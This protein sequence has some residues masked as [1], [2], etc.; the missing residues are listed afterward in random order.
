MPLSLVDDADYAQEIIFGQA[1]GYPQLCVRN[2]AQGIRPNLSLAENPS[3]FLVLESTVE[4]P[5]GEFSHLAATWDG[6][7]MKLFVNGSPA[8]EMVVDRAPVATECPFF[9]GG[10]SDACGFNG[11][12]FH[13]V[14]DEL[15]FY[16]RALSAAEIAAI[17]SAGVAGKCPPLLPPCAPTPDGIL[18]WW[19]GEGEANDETGRHH[20]QAAAVAYTNGLVGSAMVFDG[21]ASQVR[22]PFDMSLVS[23]EFSVETWLK[24]LGPVIDEWDQ[25]VVFGQALGS[26]SLLVEPGTDGVRPVF[27]FTMDPFL[28]PAVISD[29]EL[30]IHEFSHVAGTWDGTMLRIYVN[31]LLAGEVMPG[32]SLYFSTCDFFIG[33][34]S[35]S[36][37]SYT[38]DGGYFHGV[39]DELSVYGRALSQT[40]IS[41]IFAA[42]AAGKCP[43]PGYVLSVQTSPG[44]SVLREPDASEYRPGQIVTLTAMA[45]PG[46]TFARWEGDATGTEI[47]ID[48]VMDTNK[49]V[50]AVFEDVAAPEI[51]IVTPAAGVTENRTFALGGTIS[52]NIAVASA[53]WEWNG[54]PAGPLELTG[55]EFLIEG[56]QLGWGENHIR[57]VASDTTGNSAAAHVIVQWVP[58]RILSVESPDPIQE[59]QSVTFRIQ[60]SSSGE[61]GGASFLLRY[62]PDYLKQPALEW[63]PAIDSA[64][65]QVN[66]EIPGE[67]RATFALPAVP[68]PPG[69]QTLAMVT[70]R[71]RSVPADLTS[72]LELQLLDIARP[73]GD[74]IPSG[75]AARSGSATILLRRVVGD[76]NANDR[77]DAGDATIVQR[78]LIGLEPVRPWDQSGN[79][80]NQNTTLD[81]GDVIRILRAVVGLDPQPMR[82]ELRPMNAQLLGSL[83]MNADRLSGSPG[84]R[85]TLRVHLKDLPS[86]ISAVSLRLDYPTNALRLLNSQSHRPGSA[87]PVTAVAVWNV[88]PAQNDYAIQSGAVSVAFGSALP[89]PATEGALA[90]FVF[91]VQEG[92]SE[93]RQWPIRLSQAEFTADGYDMIAFPDATLYFIGRE[94][95]QPQLLASPAGDAESGFTFSFLG[96]TGLNYTVEVSND[97]VEWTPLISREGTD[98][99]ITIQ[100]ET[101]A[102]SHQRYYRVRSE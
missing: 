11:H 54:Q 46:F 79:D 36:C 14:I 12:F 50:G 56:L 69:T 40:E 58:A 74:S 92:Q 97:L 2:G 76:N 10:W 73:T 102:G 89:W 82:S 60:L 4:I 26:P 83:A 30:P 13:G 22:V 81:S 100:D 8:G 20:G 51:Q 43:P 23:S 29:V 47:E 88:A 91:E 95:L 1:F 70:L 80:V 34:L 93:R 99:I 5:V 86:P 49:L 21:E 87:V 32:Y 41:R 9:I 31:G 33:G 65:N 72:G 62:D 38:F 28:A 3:T 63:L 52:D 19:R 17:H 78:L 25:D 18:A 39:V 45:E 57:V 59:G 68:V 64:L 44:G 7:A 96:E 67:L 98:E 101:A 85:V 75:S 16:N 27:A 94:P 55:N 48:L 42:G 71:S 84:E 15:S 24:P 77:W 37:A 66:T 6:T 53:F 90:E 35:G 61:V